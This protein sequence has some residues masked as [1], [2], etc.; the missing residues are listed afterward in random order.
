MSGSDPFLISGG[1]I[2]GLITAYAL[3]L[4]GFP[5]R[6]FEQS[7]EFAEVGAGIQLGPNIFRVLEKVGLKDA[8]LADAHI[9]PAQEMR[10]AL[11]GELI[12][13]I[14]LGQ[15]FSDYFGGQPYAVT[16][17]ADIH[18]TFLK[19]CQGSNLI[20]LETS[21]KVE[22]YEED[23]AGVTVTL[24]NGE[25]VKGRALIGC[26]GQWSKIRERIVGD[27]KPRVSG[28]IAYRAVLKRNEVPDDLWRPDVVL[29]AGPRTHFVH[30]PLRRGELYNLVAV[31]HSDRYEEGWDAEGAK[32]VMWQH[33]KMQVP[34]VT[35]LLE[36]INT[37]R[38]WVLCDR[39]P[40]K[41]WTQGN[42][43]LLGDAAHPMLQYL[44]QGACMA[45]EDAIILA[46]KVAEKPDDLPAA[47]KA[48]EQA[49]YLRTG[50]T[51][52][53]ARVYGEFYHARGVAA[54]LRDM[55]VGGRTEQQAR[56]GIAWLYG[57][58]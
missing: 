24:N 49:R 40:V 42:V 34:Q 37:W 33:F 18:A 2:G 36:Q 10:N 13:N 29:W 8:V 31:F 20:T 54:E 16:H 25:K 44:A 6:L 48:Y 12:T 55:A 56:E 28:H 38:M 57:G 9:P 23:G 22:D 26:D 52:I 19:A 11:T 53:M 39:E 35:R 51:Q 7:K 4:K 15:A 27:G 5:V 58:S 50:R 43:T 45:T 21:R 1:G 47:F 3:A 41:N 32:D 30:Y 17:R 46:E 14:P